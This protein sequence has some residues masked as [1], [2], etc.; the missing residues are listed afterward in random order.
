MTFAEAVS[1]S[2]SHPHAQECQ[3]SSKVFLRIVPQLGQVCD[4][5][6]GFTKTTVRP[7]FAALTTTICVNVLHPASKIDL[8]KPA[9]AAAP[10]GRQVPFPSCLGLGVAVRLL[11]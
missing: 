9:L 11:V 1:R 2:S 5:F 6:D 8:F 10:F 3:R 7:A 4:V